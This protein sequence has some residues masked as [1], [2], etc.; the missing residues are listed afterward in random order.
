MKVVLSNLI[1]HPINRIYTAARTCYSNENTD[2]IFKESLNKTDEEMLKLI[3]HVLDSHHESVLEHISFTFYI[4]DVS[5]CMA[6]Q[7]IRHRL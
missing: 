1:D 2:I 4:S 7:L 5:R 6:M 3:R